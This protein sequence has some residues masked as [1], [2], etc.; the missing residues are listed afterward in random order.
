MASEK[1][2]PLTRDE[3]LSALKAQQLIQQTHPP[4]SEEWQE[5]SKEIYRLAEMLTG[6]PPK[7]ARGRGGK[8]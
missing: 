5:A 3:I 2:T 4:S 7:D 8:S 6:K 1:Y